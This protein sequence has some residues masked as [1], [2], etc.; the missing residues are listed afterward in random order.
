MRM[1]SANMETGKRKTPA[2]DPAARA[3]SS[4]RCL[5]LSQPRTL[6]KLGATRR[7]MISPLLP[8]AKKNLIRPRY[9]QCFGPTSTQGL[10]GGT[11]CSQKRI[12]Q[13]TYPA[14]GSPDFLQFCSARFS[15][16]WG[17]Q[18]P[19]TN[20]TCSLTQT[21][22]NAE[23]PWHNRTERAAANLPKWIA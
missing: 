20:L 7:P 1:I 18:L 10:V 16:L 4:D 14:Q 3:G 17:N 8:S 9:R 12:G 21:P 13:C 11:T 5:N 15:I 19:T 23:Q 6:S 2:A 22:N